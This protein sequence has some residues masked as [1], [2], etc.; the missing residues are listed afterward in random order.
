M[1]ISDQ[2][3]TPE[4]INILYV[5]DEVN[6]LTAFK[7]NFRRDYKVFTA[8]NAL[9][10][11]KIVEDNNI[12]IIISDQ[13]MPHMTGVEFF[14]SILHD[15]PEPIRILLTGYADIEAVIDAIN[16]G[17]VYRYITKPWDENELRVT[18]DNAFEVFHLREENK[19]L[20]ESLIHANKQL[21][22]MLRQKLL[23]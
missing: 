19:R 15:H 4:K 11:R 3:T 1:E 17:Q 6:N 5:D 18:I 23:S 20:M 10:G 21:E 9:D 16:R 14:A 22:F 13:R 7:A 8:E 12:H 2:N